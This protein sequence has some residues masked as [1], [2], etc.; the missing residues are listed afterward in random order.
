MAKV[1]RESKN[2]SQVSFLSRRLFVVNVDRKKV[3]W[4]KLKKADPY[5][6]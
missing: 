5:H 1:V 3:M 2:N 6:D 4:I